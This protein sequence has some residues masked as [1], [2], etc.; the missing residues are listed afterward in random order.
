V[1]SKHQNIFFS[2][3]GVE[4]QKTTVIGSTF[5]LLL[6]LSDNDRPVAL[7]DIGLQLNIPCNMLVCLFVCLFVCL[8]SKNM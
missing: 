1:S 5:Q 6:R 3:H 2:V 4:S 7:G 8:R